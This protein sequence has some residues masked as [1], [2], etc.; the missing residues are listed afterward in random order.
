MEP[1]CAEGFYYTQEVGDVEIKSGSYMCYPNFY[2]TK[3]PKLE[4]ADPTR[5]GHVKYIAFYIVDP[6]TRLVS[7]AI[8]PPQQPGWVATTTDSLL[9][10][11]SALAIKNKEKLGSWHA[12]SNKDAWHKFNA[13]MIDDFTY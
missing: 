5:P 4:L 11:S 13:I 10:T 12:K 6:T 1:T 7:T 9:Q 3:M 2:Q 8:V